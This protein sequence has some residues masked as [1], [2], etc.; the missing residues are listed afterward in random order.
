MFSKTAFQSLL[1]VHATMRFTA[2]FPRACIYALQSVPYACLYAFHCLLCAC[3]YAFH[4]LLSLRMPLWISRCACPEHASMHLIVY[5][6]HASLHF[7]VLLSL[8]MRLCASLCAS[9]DFTVYF[10]CECLYALDSALALRMPSMQ[11]SSYFPPL[12]MSLS[13]FRLCS[14]SCGDVLRVLLLHLKVTTALRV[15]FCT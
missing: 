12:C 13:S 9:M 2:H 15:L 14:R 3:H 4:C 11:F 10:P 5:S 1:S 7:S 8:R 6:A